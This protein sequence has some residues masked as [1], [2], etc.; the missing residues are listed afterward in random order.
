MRGECQGSRA[1]ACGICIRKIQVEIPKRR[2]GVERE[3]RT[4]GFPAACTIVAEISSNYVGMTSPCSQNSLE[5][6]ISIGISALPKGLLRCSFR[7]TKPTI[8]RDSLRQ[9]LQTLRKQRR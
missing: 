4:E 6:D 7:P 1:A 8:Y 5:R 2:E 3:A 9:F